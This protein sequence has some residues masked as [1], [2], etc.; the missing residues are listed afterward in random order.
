MN[1]IRAASP[2]QPK[3]AE[4]NENIDRHS[5]SDN[6]MRRNL[7]TL[8]LGGMIENLLQGRLC[9]IGEF[10]C[11]L[12]AEVLGRLLEAEGVQFTID[13]VK[14]MLGFPTKFRL[15]VP[16]SMAHRARWILSDSEFTDRELDFLAT[17]NFRRDE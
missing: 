2:P 3:H 15:L 4:S 17:G 14:P 12:S 10:D 1:K 6:N 5:E 7:L 13:P 16:D 11:R 8:L 9:A